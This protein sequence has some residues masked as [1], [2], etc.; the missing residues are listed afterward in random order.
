MYLI[1]LT[2]CIFLFLSYAFRQAKEK[3]DVQQ[4]FLDKAMA[5]F[6]PAATQLNEEYNLGAYRWDLDQKKGTLT[7]SENGT[8]KVIATVQ[9][10]GSYSTYSHTW[11][12]AWANESVSEPL[13]T[14]ATQVKAYGTEHKYLQLTTAKF[15]YP[16]DSC[17]EL[18]A[19]AGYLLKAKGA[20]RGPMTDGYVY[21]LITDIKKVD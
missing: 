5:S 14:G 19:V 13:K 2:F 7:F 16:E 18:T 1:K 21:M 3:V 9:I 10:A 15:E 4:K 11:M 12:W 17:W 20:Y 8:P 6:G